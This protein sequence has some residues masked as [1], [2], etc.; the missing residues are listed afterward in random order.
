MSNQELDNLFKKKLNKL[1]K[2][3]KA[4]A[5][6]K[7]QAQTNGK[8]AG[9]PYLRIAAAILILFTL[10]AILWVSIDQPIEQ[11]TMADKKVENSNT[12]SPIDDD[13]IDQE[14]LMAENEE[15]N[16][17]SENEEDDTVT[18]QDALKQH[19]KS[20]PTPKEKIE[21]PVQKKAETT[22]VEPVQKIEELAVE[23]ENI[24]AVEKSDATLEIEKASTPQEEQE[25]KSGTTLEFDISEFTKTQ[26]SVAQ[27]NSNQTKSDSPQAT[28]E[29]GLSKVLTV[30]KD[31]KSEAGLGNLREAKNEI[32]AL[33]FKKDNNGSK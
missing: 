18:D 12:K 27:A 6:D 24:A 4:D 5:W 3:P 32:L 19:I 9:W 20:N 31:I 30:M 23:K 26:T 11:P 15:I 16:T 14:E 29:K 33:N 2:A 25:V 1:E 28:D 13:S 22:K 7:I 10:G 21:A 8:K 17:V